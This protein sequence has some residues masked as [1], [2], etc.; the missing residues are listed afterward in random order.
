MQIRS[1]LASQA[2][3][4]KYYLTPGITKGQVGQVDAG[5]S[6]NFDSQ[7]NQYYVEGSPTLAAGEIKTISLKIGSVGQIDQK[8]A[9]ANLG[10]KVNKYVGE[11]SPTV[12]P[13]D[14]SRGACRDFDPRQTS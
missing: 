5:L 10:D 14:C 9:A 12:A 11:I 6:L 2:A 1:A 7:R 4:I 8:V 3:A 13:S